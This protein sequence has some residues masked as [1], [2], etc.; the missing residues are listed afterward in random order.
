MFD[1]IELVREFFE[2]L[3]AVDETIVARVA[4]A[5]CPFCG[6]PPHRGATTP[7]A[8]RRAC[9]GRGGGLQASVQPVLWLGRV[10]PVVRRPR[11]VRFLGRR[12][13][14]A[15]VVIVAERRRGSRQRPRARF[16][17]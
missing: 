8:A 14:V 6:G 17:G 15:A 7:A 12:V 3:T 16:G 2:G 5:A 10:L 9:R 1:Q 11:P 4:A 13:Y